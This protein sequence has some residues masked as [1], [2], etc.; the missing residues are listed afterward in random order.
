VSLAGKL[1]ADDEARALWEAF[2][3][4]MDEH[5]GDFAGFAK[6]R[7]YESVRPEYQRGRAVLV[8]EA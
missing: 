6:L 4:Y 3:A 8:I 5:R 7:G 1:L 2:S